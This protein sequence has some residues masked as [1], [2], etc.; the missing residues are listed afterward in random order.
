MLLKICMQVAMVSNIMYIKSKKIAAYGN[1][2]RRDL[3]AHYTIV[4][5]ED[6]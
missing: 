2:G 3:E 5:K 1:P 4:H 6:D